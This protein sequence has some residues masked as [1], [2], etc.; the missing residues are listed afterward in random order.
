MKGHKLRN[1]VRSAIVLAILLQSLIFGIGLLTSGAFSDM[2][3]RPYKVMESYVSE[4]NAQLTHFMNGVLQISDALERELNDRWDETGLQDRLLETLNHMTEASVAF[5]LNLDDKEAVAFRDNDTE[6]YSSGYRDI[7]CIVGD[8]KSTDR[9]ER[10]AD[11]IP[12]PNGREWD[13]IL[14][15][16]KEPEHGGMW[17]ITEGKLYYLVFQR[18]QGQRCIWGFE[19]GHDMLESYLSIENPPYEGMR[20]LLLSDDQVVHSVDHGLIGTAYKCEQGENIISLKKDGAQYQGVRTE[21]SSYGHMNTR[22]LHV[23]VV[24]YLSELVS[25]S[26][27]GQVSILG[28]YVISIAIAVAVSYV[29]ISMV[30]KPIQKLQEDIAEQKPEE[31]HFSDCGIIEIDRIYRSLNDMAQKLER[32]YSR[33]DFAMEVV[34]DN[35]GVFEFIDDHKRVKLSSSAARILDIPERAMDKEGTIEADR[36]YRILEKLTEIPE[37]EESYSFLSQNG[38]EQAVFIRTKIEEQ[39]EFGIVIDKTNEYR[40]IQRLRKLSQN[41]QLTGLYNGAYLR[42]EGQRLLEQ[43]KGKVNACVFCD[44]DGLKYVNDNFGHKTGDRYLRAMAGLLREIAEGE[45]CIPVRIAGDEFVLFFYGYEDRRYLERLVVDAYSRRPII[46]LSGQDGKEEEY[47][48]SASMGMAYGQRGEDNIEDMISRADK[49]MYRVKK[50][51]KNGFTVYEHQDEES[52]SGQK[53]R[54]LIGSF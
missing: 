16:W 25:L 4:K 17:Y 35:S 50:G 36:W 5:F 45:R 41:D 34:S 33:Y 20:I 53:S 10:S 52:S 43:N 2:V 21:L 26:Y 18:V 28:I 7:V 39:G 8:L 13:N 51:G 49:A 12:G 11:W 30:L 29:A 54:Q 32:T 48:L 3:K 31:I 1:R 15:M 22:S 19:I 44:L 24:C 38:E 40:E 23:G 47:L 27:A 9:V 37:L 42:K 46:R 6:R 14:Q